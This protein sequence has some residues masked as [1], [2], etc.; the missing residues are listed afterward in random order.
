MCIVH[1]IVQLCVNN[2]SM[3]ICS[4][5]YFKP[6]KCQLHRRLIIYSDLD[7]FFVFRLCHGDIK[8]FKMVCFDPKL[9]FFKIDRKNT[10]IKKES[11]LTLDRKVHI[12]CYCASTVNNRVENRSLAFCVD[13]V[14]KGSTKLEN[15]NLVSVD[16]HFLLL[17]INFL[18]W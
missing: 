11:S 12:L 18:V 14:R 2:I 13:L 5:L 16:L 8:L 7:K 4:V 1:V 9:H 6:L 10:E 15:C 3:I 17:A